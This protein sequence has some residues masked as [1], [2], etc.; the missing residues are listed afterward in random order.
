MYG[1]SPVRRRMTTMPE[2]YD[3]ALEYCHD[4]KLSPDAPRPK[5]TKDWPPENVALLE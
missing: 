2:R 4:K 1:M 3:Q 5:P